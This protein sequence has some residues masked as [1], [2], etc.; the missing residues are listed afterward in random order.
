MQDSH[1]RRAPLALRTAALALAALASAASAQSI[2]DAPPAVVPHEEFARAFLGA[3]G[4]ADKAPEQ[5]DIEALIEAEYARIQVGLYD[6]RFPAE[7]LADE[8]VAADLR[9]AMLALLAAQEHFLGWVEEARPRPKE[10]DAD[11]KTFRKW[12]EGLNPARMGG[13]GDRDDRDALLGLG[14]KESVA[15][16]SQRFAAYMR[17]G[18]PLGLQREEPRASRI[19][20]A[21]TRPRFLQL[22]CFAG[23][24]Y[25][26]L[27]SVFWD[28]E[29]SVWLACR[30]Q[31]TQVICLQFASPD[32]KKGDFELGLP[33]DYKNETVLRQHLVHFGAQALFDNYYGDDIPPWLSTG[34]ALDMVLDLFGEVDTRIEGDLRARFTQEMAV[35]VPGGNSGGGSLPPVNPDGRWRQDKGRGYFIE[36]LRRTQSEGASRVKDAREKYLHFE[37]EDDDK[38]EHITVRAPFLGSAATG[39]VLPEESFLGDYQEF[40]RAYKSGFG[41]WLQSAAAGSSKACRKSFAELLDGL[42]RLPEGAGFEELVRELYGAPLSGDHPDRESLEGRFLSWLSKQK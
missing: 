31:K 23:W 41:H 39:K 34:L 38:R 19:L 17:A 27:R 6:L 7:D 25:P 32:V 5:V 11:I 14:A 26:D 2:I 30:I 15:L 22:V 28:E 13:G 37:L 20:L 8:E 36:I 3:R 10:V 35:F 4:L 24:Y 12:L 16:A 42:A 29:L 18:G 21:P 9:D 1:A 40:F 33:L